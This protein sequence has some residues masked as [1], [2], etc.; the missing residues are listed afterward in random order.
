MKY[1]PECKNEL[2]VKR[3]EGIERLVCSSDC[4]YVFWDN[5]A[6][7]VAA[8]VQYRNKYVLTRN[9]QWPPGIFSLITGF[10]EKD[11]HP[12]WAV[13]REVKEEL[14]LEAEVDRFIGF[15]PFKK[16]NQLIVA[17]SLTATGKLQLNEELTEV[18]LLTK[19]QLETYDF[20]LLTLTSA[21]VKDWLATEKEV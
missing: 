13:V 2:V 14:S 3:I 19:D 17:Y 7:V 21:I 4:G 20:N 15:Y 12:A 5:P 11:E 8:L 1:C 6:P 16:M 10:I 18:K 9:A